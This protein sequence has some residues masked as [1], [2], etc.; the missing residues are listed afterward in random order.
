[1]TENWYD[2][3][4]LPYVLHCACGLHPVAQQRRQVIPKAQGRVLEVGIGT[5]LNMPFYDR[6]RVQ[7]IVG[8]DPAMSM[9]RLAHKQIQRSGIEVE[10]VGLSAEKLPLTDASFDSVVCTYSLCSMADPVQALREMRRVL[11]PTGQLL[12]CEHGLSPDPRVVRQ[13]NKWQP[14]WG[15][16]AGGCKLDRDVPSLLS[17]AGFQSEL[18][19][20]YIW[21]PKAL[22][23]NYWGIVSPI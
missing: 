15:K 2:R 18:E 16:I 19:S 12:L 6:Q 4:L 13:Q 5:G 3:H 23:Y 17:Q 21:G 1:M 10:L 22:A 20:G 8:V 14:L 9:H 11:A 7:S